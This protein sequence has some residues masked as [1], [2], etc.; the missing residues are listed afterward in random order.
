LLGV[1]IDCAV[2]AGRKGLSI[3]NI[4]RGRATRKDRRVACGGKCN[5]TELFR[6]FAFIFEGRADV[7]REILDAARN[8]AHHSKPEAYE[9]CRQDNPVDRDR[10][11]FVIQ[12]SGIH[13]LVPKITTFHCALMATGALEHEFPA[14]FWRDWG[15]MSVKTCIGRN[16]AVLW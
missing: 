6:E 12:K 1:I 9:R 14:Y 10:A 4:I 2:V 16:S 13:I 8:D 3:G 15:K 7:G 11:G 5:A